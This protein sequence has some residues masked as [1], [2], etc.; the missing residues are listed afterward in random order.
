MFLG[1][2]FASSAAHI[3]HI[4]SPILK[5]SQLPSTQASY[6]GSALQRLKK[7]PDQ[8]LV[9]TELLLAAWIAVQTQSYF[10]AMA[11][12]LWSLI[13]QRI[14][15]PCT[16]NHISLFFVVWFHHHVVIYTLYKPRRVQTLLCLFLLQSDQCWTVDR[17]C[18]F[19]S[20]ER[21]DKKKCVLT[22]ICQQTS[23]QLFLDR[24]RERESD[25]E[26][27]DWVSECRRERKSKWKW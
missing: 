27:T 20:V 26:R 2:S 21:V 14:R 13:F 16:G 3:W 12:F 5:W 8:R 22:S 25:T 17:I 18:Y 1:A 23:H 19:V 11:W 4:K 24:R 10:A 9:S 7:W 6:K 15:S